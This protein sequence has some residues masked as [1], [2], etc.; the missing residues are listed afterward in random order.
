MFFYNDIWKAQLCMMLKDSL[1]KQVY[2]SINN[3][4]SK[5]GFT[6]LTMKRHQLLYSYK[7]V[8]NTMLMI[9]SFKVSEHLTPNPVP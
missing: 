7:T 3:M 9:M 1:S 2:N 6:I 5:T 8:M 4:D